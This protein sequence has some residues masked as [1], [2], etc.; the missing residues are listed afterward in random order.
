[1]TDI[2]GP[3]NRERP[4]GHELAQETAPP[5]YPG[6]AGGRLSLITDIGV[7]LAGI[8]LV[9]APFVL[10]L[11]GAA[12]WNTLLTG[13]AT[14]LLAAA[15]LAAPPKTSR[16]GL[17]H[18]A[19]GVWLIASPFL[20]GYGDDLMASRTSVVTGAVIAVL[21]LASAASGGRSRSV[22]RDS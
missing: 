8:W 10:G 4:P 18:L 2:K 9:I 21:A 20:L 15:R 7:L 22:I 17:I 16:L 3:E 12:F 14:V 19:L 13:A 5:T 11:D 1:M 6:P